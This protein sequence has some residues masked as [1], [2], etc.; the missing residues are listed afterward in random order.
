MSGYD[1]NSEDYSH[2]GFGTCASI[3]VYHVKRQT[4]DVGV[5]LQFLDIT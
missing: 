3:D 4:V 1:P 2:L 5:Q